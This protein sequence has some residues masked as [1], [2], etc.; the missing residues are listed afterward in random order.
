MNENA[1]KFLKEAGKNEEFKPSD[2]TELSI[3]DLDTVAGGTNIIIN[4]ME[5][6]NVKPCPRCGST[7]YGYVHGFHEN[8]CLDCGFESGE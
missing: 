4:G 2:D 3:E 7:N 8:F 6:N 1:K 5:V